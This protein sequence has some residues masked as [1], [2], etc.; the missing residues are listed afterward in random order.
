VSDKPEDPA[1]DGQP[2]KSSV[3]G[4]RNGE[5]LAIGTLSG[6]VHLKNV[7]NVP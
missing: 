2:S 4:F 3:M 7:S 1:V 6:H 5:C